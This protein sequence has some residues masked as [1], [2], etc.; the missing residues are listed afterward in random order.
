MTTKQ[1]QL[2]SAQVLGT[3]AFTSGIKRVAH[4][5]KELENMMTGRKIGETPKGEASSIAIMNAWYTGWD[6]A[7]LY[8][9][10]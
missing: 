7:N 8:G 6:N 1:I 2:V 3:K 4:F 9:V 10:N 5:D